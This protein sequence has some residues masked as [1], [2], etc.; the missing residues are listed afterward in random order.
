MADTTEEP[1]VP[2][3]VIAFAG[4]RAQRPEEPPP[5]STAQ[6]LLDRQAAALG[7]L[8]N[9][10]ERLARVMGTV[11]ARRP[12]VAAEEPAAPR[13]PRTETSFFPAL[14]AVTI[15]LERATRAIADDVAD[16]EAMF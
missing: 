9:A 13:S 7:L 3:V 14:D 1:S 2:P 12:G 6:Q 5:K 8:M 4:N 10:Q 15:E 11:H 16:L